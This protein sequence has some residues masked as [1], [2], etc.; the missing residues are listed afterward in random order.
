LIE[1]KNSLNQ[2]ISGWTMRFLGL[3]TFS[4]ST[5]SWA[6]YLR[7]TSPNRRKT[8]SIRQKRLSKR[9]IAAAVAVAVGASTFAIS[10]PASAA[11]TVTK[12]RVFG[13]DRYET[14]A[15]VALATFPS[16]KHVI[17]ASGEDY[18]DGLVAAGLS[19]AAKQLAG[20]GNGAP[21][22]L[23]R[24]DSLPAA[25]L[26]AIATITGGTGAT[27]HIVGGTAAVG[28]AVRTQLTTLGYALNEI[29]GVDRFDTAAQIAVLAASLQPIGR[30]TLPGSTDKRTA[31]VATGRNFADALSAGAP[32]FS[33]GHPILLTEQ[34]SLPAVTSDALTT[35][36][37]EQVVLMG[38]TAAVSTAVED[39]IKAKGI[40]V[41]RIAGTDRYD[42]AKQLADI[43]IN[44][45]L[46]FDY[47]NQGTKGIV[48]VSGV[49]FADALAAGP[50]AGL[51]NAPMLLVRPCDIPAPTAAFHVENAI[52][53]NLIRAIGGAAAICDAVLD[54]A[55]SV[56]TQVTPSVTILAEQ[57]R[58]FLTVTFSERVSTTLDTSKV[59]F[60]SVGRTIA[61]GGYSAVD[62]GTGALANTATTFRIAITPSVGTAFNTGDVVNVAAGLGTTVP[63]A[64]A[65]ART[66]GAATY[67]VLADTVRPTV[68]AIT[69]FPT[70][71]TFFVSFSEP[72][73]TTSIN[74]GSVSR[75]RDGVTIDS[76]PGI[77]AVEVN[78]TTNTWSFTLGTPLVSGDVIKVAGAL[79]TP[80]TGVLDLAGNPV[81][82]TQKIVLVDNT[83]PTLLSAT[84]ST[85]IATNATITVSNSN[86]T[87]SAVVELTAKTS[88]ATAGALGNGWKVNFTDVDGRTT[89]TIA[90]NNTT[91]IITVSA[92]ITGGNA[93][94]VASLIVAWNSSPA[95]DLFGIEV[96]TG[97][98]VTLDGVGTTFTAAG[99][100]TTVTVVHQFS[101]GVVYNG[102]APK[103]YRDGSLF[104]AEGAAFTTFVEDLSEPVFD[105][106]VTASFD[107]GSV[108]DLPVLG[109]AQIR[110]LAG[111]F[112]DLAGNEIANTAVTVT[113]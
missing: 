45:A 74:A 49:N 4:S 50:H 86:P 106:K 69:A 18:A 28:Q 40:S 5:N 17:L 80:N 57:G 104:A 90:I 82:A 13:A 53:V 77:T 35:I 22:L 75:T 63:T 44:P 100:L 64:P 113:G 81:V 19:S 37:A 60:A 58:N 52:A 46:D 71:S 2:R 94:T 15:K 33:G 21:V 6:S 41:I 26:N 70:Q 111:A 99:G 87:N 20:G 67:T 97:G 85:K 38:G 83:K 25:T 102:P 95:N 12:S 10:S 66:S 30:L 27:V 54:G 32:A 76:T 112:E 93:A 48:L 96:G 92:D 9:L 79:G 29:S 61:A 56:V 62:P 7:E 101:E 88:A 34:G 98:W 108:A 68:T 105:G 39:A 55:V 36:A 109:T 3:Q 78:S 65:V 42:T 72:V 16:G 73:T 11:Q 110:I 43:L 107:T 89:P 47:Y 23:T 24:K 84:G 31:I 51:I 1:T 59:T 14:A 8:L 91:R 103:W